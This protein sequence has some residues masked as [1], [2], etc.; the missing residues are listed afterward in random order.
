[1]SR[2]I[3]AFRLTKLKKFLFVELFFKKIPLWGKN[4]D[5]ITN[6]YVYKYWVISN[7]SFRIT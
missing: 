6:N 3:G 2:I 5:D 7:N 1:M 4:Q